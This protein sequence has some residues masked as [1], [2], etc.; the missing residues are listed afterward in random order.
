MATLVLAPDLYTAP[1][2]TAI[3]GS[4]VDYRE[5]SLTAAQCVSTNIIA[6]GVIPAN[7]RLLGGALDVGNAM[8]TNGTTTAT[9]Q[10]G[11]LNSYYNQAVP[12]ASVVASY[13]SAST[14]TV[15]GGYYDVTATTSNFVSTAGL[16]P[17]TQIIC[18]MSTTT[19]VLS[20]Q[21]TDANYG[22][23]MLFGNGIVAGHMNNLNFTQIV[24]I[25]PNNDRIVAFQLTAACATAAATKVGLTLVLDEA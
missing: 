4:R 1:P 11:I 17:S 10:I 8:D 15:A 18:N 25:D 14:S 5:I 6:L 21:I 20:V 22:G 9:F 3:P 7:H 24:G 16:Y 13:N 2:K 23:K 19:N 12:T